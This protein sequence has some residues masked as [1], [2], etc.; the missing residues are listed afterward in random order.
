MNVHHKEPDPK[1]KPEVKAEPQADP[2]SLPNLLSAP[3]SGGQPMK[4]SLRTQAKA[5]PPTANLPNGLSGSIYI[6]KIVVDA[7]MSAFTLTDGGTYTILTSSTAMAGGQVVDFN[8][9][10]RVMDFQVTTAV[11]GNWYIY[12][13]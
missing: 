1:A 7:T 6:Y 5:S 10:L 3:Y 8:P 13:R 9:P 2:K 12:T 4:F 11:G